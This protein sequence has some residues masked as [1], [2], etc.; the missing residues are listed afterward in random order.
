[1][2]IAKKLTVITAVAASCSPL[3]ADTIFDNTQNASAFSARFTPGLLE[4]GNQISFSPYIGQL[5][6]SGY[7]ITN[8]YFQ[9][10]TPNS[11]LTADVRFYKN[12]GPSGAPGTKIFDSG[13]F[14]LGTTPNT[15]F[16]INFDST[17]FGGGLA[18]NNNSG[19]TWTVQFG[20]SQAQVDLYSPP[21][22]A[23]GIFPDYWQNDG[24][25]WMLETN[26][27]GTINFGAQFQATVVPEPSTMALWLF[28]GTALTV[29]M[30]R[31]RRKA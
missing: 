14:T 20:D 8:F 29:M 5:G 21:P 31:F 25:G 7:V 2:N 16:N 30:N 6:A 13:S 24:S 12:D 27:A 1:M 17:D 15:D 4:V 23:G 10:Y 19:L 11:S 22:Q 18:Y 3:L 9:A 26:S 28:G